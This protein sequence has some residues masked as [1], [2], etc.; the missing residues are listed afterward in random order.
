VE[1]VLIVK[2]GEVALRGKNRYI[3]ENKLIAAIENNLKGCPG[4]YVSRELGRYVVCTHSAPFDFGLVIPKVIS[5]LGIISCCPAVRSR[6][7]S[8]ENIKKLSLLH[9]KK[10]YPDAP[11]RGY[12]FRVTAHRSH[13]DYPVSSQEIAADI[14]ECII[15]GAEG[16]KVNLKEPEINLRAELRNQVYI[17]TEETKGFGGLP[18]GSCGKTMALLSAGIDSPVASFLMARRGV[19]VEAVYFHTPP[20][21]SQRALL[22]VTDICE[23]LKTFT[24]SFKLNVV[25]FTDIQML[26]KE[27]TPPE[28]F[29]IMLKRSMMRLAEIL[30]QKNDCQALT[31]GDSV[32]QVASQ[33]LKSIAAIDSAVSIPVLRPLAG[34][35]KNEIIDWAKKIGTFDISIR[36][37]QDCCTLFVP[38]HPETKPKVSIIESFEKSIDNLYDITKETAENVKVY[39]F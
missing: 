1:E 36:P 17:Y 9:M 23:V 6:D 28:K 24:A 20:Y 34:M 26:I 14:G 13:K 2:F 12:T 15:E 5:V 10:R 39:N 32:G 31:T 37:F 30:A 8:M 3:F 16:F 7:M 33:T 11:D 29:T 21:T 22:K 18:V 27:K 25:N 4:Y 19:E 38:P 35:D